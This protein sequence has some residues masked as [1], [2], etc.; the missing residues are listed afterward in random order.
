MNSKISK[1]L[2]LS[3]LN[4]IKLQPGCNCLLI[5]NDDFKTAKEIIDNIKSKSIDLLIIAPIKNIKNTE[6]LEEDCKKEFRNIETSSI[7][8]ICSSIDLNSLIE[9][10]K[11]SNIDN[12]NVLLLAQITT[13]R[14]L[15]VV[16]NLNKDLL[17]TDLDTEEKV[18][19]IRKVFNFNSLRIL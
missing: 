3:E 12:L 16:I 8:D 11:I 15:D 17:D 5:I 6:L 4:K 13:A 7:E 18:N 19:L 1:S 10:N 14:R 2:I 9:L